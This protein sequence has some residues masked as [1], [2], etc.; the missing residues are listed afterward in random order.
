MPRRRSL[1]A[2]PSAADLTAAVAAATDELAARDPVLAR[3]VTAAG[4]CEL[5]ARR[6]LS[7]FGS[8][9]RSITFQQLAGRAAATIF[10]R[11]V[12]AATGGGE[13]VELDLY[14]E[15]VADG[16]EPDRLL[17]EMQTR[18]GMVAL[19]VEEVTFSFWASRFPASILAVV[20]MPL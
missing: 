16:L 8:L 7:H 9:C 14:E 11:F 6:G 17:P 13:A 20:E 15:V 18:S 3:L 4:P 12:A 5:D 10:G 19:S 1:S 2:G